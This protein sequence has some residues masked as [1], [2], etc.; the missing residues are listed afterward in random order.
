[1]PLFS[2]IRFWDIRFESEIGVYEL[3]GKGGG[4]SADIEEEG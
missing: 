2:P 4:V 1:M 3:K